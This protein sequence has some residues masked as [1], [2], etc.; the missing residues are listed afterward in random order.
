MAPE[1]FYPPT[2]PLSQISLLAKLG[3]LLEDNSFTLGQLHSH[4]LATVFA[5]QFDDFQ[6]KWFA[7]NAA[8]TALVI[9]LGKANGTLY[10]TDDALD[11]FLDLLDRTLLIITKNER[12][13]SQYMF[14]FGPTPVHVLKRPIL[15]EELATVRGF[16]P[17][18]QTSPHPALAA[19]APLLIEL[20][21]RADA[22][23]AQQL[24]AELA[25]KDFDIL[26]GMKTLIDSYNAL[27][28]TV[29]GQLAAI[30]H[31]NP[32]A[33]LPA[34]FADRF[35]RHES[36]KG[37]TALR[38]PKDVQAKVEA[39]KKKMDAAQKHLDS[40]AA[41]AAKKALDKQAAQ[42]AAAALEEG[43]KAKQAAD[44]KL[45]ELEKAAKAAKQKSK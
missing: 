39:H 29:Y 12:T 27:R 2:M 21:A 33:M 14:Y 24:A 13:A 32:T 11:D 26:G 3:E 37:V 10:S 43:R 1:P 19:L 20:I 25:L 30:P 6:T 38:N 5:P 4:P 40:L 35:F 18:L 31:A 22:A 28:Q 9:I 7:S 42:E 36:R 16:V 44:D 8:R 34:N 17:S 23:I 45:K 41:N 15:G